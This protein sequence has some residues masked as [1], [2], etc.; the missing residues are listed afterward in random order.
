MSA[1]EMEMHERFAQDCAAFALG[2]LTTPEQEAFVAHLETC[3][4]CRDEV[5]SLERAASVLSAAVP[6]VPAPEAVKSRVMATVDREAAMLNPGR[7]EHAAAPRRARPFR[8]GGSAWLGGRARIG[9]LAAG[10]VAAVAVAVAASGGAP[11]TRTIRAQVTAARAEVSVKLSGAH[12]EL[13]VAGMPQSP[14]NHVYEVWVKRAGAA[15]PTDALF[16]VSSAGTATVGVP[17]SI[18]G[19]RQIMVTAEP[20]GGSR[21]PTS[22]PVILATL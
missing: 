9:A 14:P 16:T 15:E 22:K 7:G 17:G 2:A 21:V 3:A 6:Q 19:V 1:E 4:A 12:A 13:D 20:N 10:A 18:A 5:A 8:R 11:G